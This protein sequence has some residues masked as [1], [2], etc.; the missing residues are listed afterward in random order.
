MKEMQE[1]NKM[2]MPAIKIWNEQRVITFKDIDEVHNRPNGTAGRNFRKNRNRFIEGEDYFELNQRDEIRRLGIERA[3]GGTPNSVILVT[4]TGYLMIVKSFKD[5]LSWDVQRQLVNT[6]F[7]A[8]ETI[9]AGTSL[10]LEDEKKYL[11]KYN[12]SWYDT[13]KW[14]MDK[15]CYDYGWERKYLYHKVLREV[16][17]F[18]NMDFFREKYFERVGREAN[19]DMDIINQYPVLQGTATRYLD[20]LLDASND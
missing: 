8:K 9:A 4:E 7:R 15:L 17:D 16:S 19:Y 1:T 12:K 6:Y 5:D 13:Q 2:E 20:F 11:A 18:W 3:Q 14:K 10:E